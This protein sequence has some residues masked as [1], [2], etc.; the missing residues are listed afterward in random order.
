MTLMTELFDL[1]KKYF[2]FYV[3]RN[4]HLERPLFHSFIGT[5]LSGE[6]HRIMYAEGK[7][8]RSVRIPVLI[9]QP[10]GTGKSEAM[11][12]LEQSVKE[13]SSA[14]NLDLKTEYTTEMTAAGLLGSPNRKKDVANYG[15]L[16]TCN[17]I[18]IDESSSLFENKE[19]IRGARNAVMMALDEHGNGMGWVSKRL[20]SLPFPIEYFTY[21]TVV[22]G[23]YWE[24]GGLMEY[25]ILNEG[26]FQRFSHV[27]K[28]YNEKE[29]RRIR[30]A[31]MDLK[32]YDPSD[33]IKPVQ[34]GIENKVAELLAT[35]KRYPQVRENNYYLKF[36]HNTKELS[37]MLEKVIRKQTKDRFNDTKQMILGT[38]A[39][40]ALLFA[41]RYATQYAI[42]NNQDEMDTESYKYAVDMIGDHLSNAVQV[43]KSLGKVGDEPDNM[44]TITIQKIVRYYTGISGGIN[45]TAL[46]DELMKY[47]E[48]H[49]WDLGKN[50]TRNFIAELVRK[51]ELKMKKGVKK[52][53]I[54]YL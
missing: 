44:R 45:Q 25:S 33:D 42:L 21:T 32:L 5:I 16:K 26:F 22:A 31:I 18:C 51:K 19:H 37:R 50:P 13:I 48:G 10:S 20:G 54:Y 35:S 38:F 24:R 12:A 46:L 53:L 23:S 39:N 2:H 30:E 3:A 8:Y 41:D 7:K 1:W 11:V 17:L 40:R 6:N 34:T 29:Q 47:K 15:A 43:L 28:P 4:E 14:C 27:F 52:E 36:T 9:L 49:G